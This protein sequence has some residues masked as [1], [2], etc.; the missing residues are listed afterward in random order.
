MTTIFLSLDAL[1]F[2]PELYPRAK[3][4]DAAIERYRASI[5]LLPPI[6]VARGGILVDGYHRW[7]AHRREGKTEIKAS[8]LGDISDAE[9]L[10]ESI[11][12][13]AAHGLQLSRADKQ[14]LAGVL[15]MQIGQH[16]HCRTRQPNRRPAR[17]LP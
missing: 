11:R 3:E 9:I 7:Q 13:N 14:R 1:Q 5:D 6:I 16:P 17:R 15:W 4:D 2:V 12:R 8:D 10:T